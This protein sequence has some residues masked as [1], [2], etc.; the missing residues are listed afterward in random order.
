[1][2]ETALQTLGERRSGE[3]APGAEIHLHAQDKTMEYTSRL[4][5]THTGA[6][7]SRN[8]GLWRRAPTGADFQA[9]YVCHPW[10]ML[11]AGAL[12]FWR[13]APYRKDL[14]WTS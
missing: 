8:C 5:G 14:C 11:D 2:E 1:M 10:G 6:G 3:G 12:C 7:S 9:G 4:W 13:T